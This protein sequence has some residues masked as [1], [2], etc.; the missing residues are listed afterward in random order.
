MSLLQNLGEEGQHCNM[1]NIHT[2]RTLTHMAQVYGLP[3]I[4]TRVLLRHSY[5][6]RS[7]SSF[8]FPSI[9]NVNA[10]VL[11]PGGRKPSGVEKTRRSVYYFIIIISLYKCCNC[12]LPLSRLLSSTTYNYFFYIP[13]YIICC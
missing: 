4:L 1:G 5:C 12:Q 8:I 11:Q 2:D 10:C 3:G 6:A 9:Y 7:C 13:C